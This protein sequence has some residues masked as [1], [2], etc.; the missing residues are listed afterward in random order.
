MTIL[1]VI[2]LVVFPYIRFRFQHP[3]ALQSNLERVN[4]YLFMTMPVQQKIEMFIKNYSYG[5][6]PFYWFIGDSH[7]LSRHEMKGYSY[8]LTLTLP[9]FLIGLFVALKNIKSSSYRAILVALLAAPFG[10]SLAELAVTR[11]LA[12]VIPTNLLIVIGLHQLLSLVKNKKREVYL[13]FIICVI[14]SIGSLFIL[15]DAL[16]H[17]PLWYQDYALYGSQWGAKQLF[18]DTI[19]PYLRE[20]PKQD[21]YVSSTWANGTDIYPKFF[22]S[23]SQV[24]MGEI[25]SYMVYKQN[26]NNMM[27]FVTTDEEYKKI[28]T[29]NKFKNIVVDKIIKYPDGTNGF[30]FI[31]LAYVDDIDAIFD[32][33]KQERQ[34]LLNQTIHL[35]G[36]EVQLNYSK[37]DMGEVSN[38][39][40]NNPKT[41]IRGFEANPF[42]LEFI[43]PS[44]TQIEKVQAVFAHMTFEINLIGYDAS[45]KKIFHQAKSYQDT[46][47]QE[48]S[49]E[50]SIRTNNIKRLRI[51]IKNLNAQDIAHI[52]VRELH[53]LGVDTKFVKLRGTLQGEPSV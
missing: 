28:I 40:D 18:V 32:R 20:H 30:Y 7:Y 13:E 39:F 41:L 9:L 16:T 51:E 45:G 3:E 38:L 25:N 42:I 23:P 12:Y 48:P 49:I 19:P 50:E 6:S 24:H 11:M 26:L 22:N 29:S 31:R 5:L 4:T 33:D 10:A 46:P 1:L 8:I 17:G 15:Q 2:A 44:P 34:R 53:L 14:L 43:F 35:L 27:T 36:K 37:L 21:I 52:H 47:A